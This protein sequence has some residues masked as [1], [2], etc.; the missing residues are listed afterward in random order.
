MCG[1]IGAFNYGENKRNVNEDVLDILQDQIGRGKEGFGISFIKED[2]RVETKRATIL[3][4]A[5]MDLYHEPNQARMAIMHHRYPTSSEN[6]L[7]QTHPIEVKSGSLKYKYLVVHNG[8]V[9]N[10]DKL[11]KRHEEE[12]GF[13]YTTPRMKQFYQSEQEEYNDSESL[14]VEVAMFIEEQTDFLTIE[15]SAAFI[16]L[17]VNKK[18]EKVNKVFFGRNESNP[19]KMHAKKG[20]LRLASEGKGEN[21]KPFKL[22][23]FKLSDFKIS[24]RKMKFKEEEEKTKEFLPGVRYEKEIGFKDNRKLLD[25]DSYSTEREKEWE[26][27][28]NQQDIAEAIEDNQVTAIEHLEDFFLTISNEQLLL[29]ED[30]EAL[31]R[32]TIKDIFREIKEAKDKAMEALTDI[33]TQEEDAREKE[34]KEEEKEG[35]I[36]QDKFNS[37]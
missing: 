29:T 18:T 35:V 10:C 1:I 12:L 32:S 13:T 15:G 20:E 23:S 30:L 27:D 25:F 3:T 26:K 22:Y 14:A 19:L 4:K 9:R 16:A 17:Q 34:E 5:V 33:F 31:T 37:K 7:S 8:V 21:I 6:K 11:R 2:K 36:I 24:K 28:L